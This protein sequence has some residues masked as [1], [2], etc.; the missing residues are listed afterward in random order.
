LRKLQQFLIFKPIERY[1][2]DAAII[3]SD[4][5]VVPQALGMTVEMLPAKGPSFPEP[6]VV[7]SDLAKLNKD[8]DV[9]KELGYVM[10]AI[11]LTRHKLQ[12]KVPLIGFSG[13]PV[14]PN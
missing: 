3:F 9:K 10:E 12:G 6:L 14:S 11:T 1:D 7:P 8:C 2:L 13:A 4:I 5:L